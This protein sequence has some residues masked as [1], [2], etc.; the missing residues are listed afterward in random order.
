MTACGKLVT[1][2]NSPDRDN[3]QAE[4][5]VEL[6]TGYP[7]SVEL[8]SSGAHPGPCA[9]VEQPQTVT[10]R[11]RWLETN[12]RRTED[13]RHASSGLGETQGRP[14]TFAE[15]A[16][17]DPAI[18]HP[19]QE[20]PCPLC[21]GRVLAKD[22]PDHLRQVHASTA[23]TA[24]HRV[25]EPPAK[26]PLAASMA[27]HPSRADRPHDQ[28]LP[29]PNDRPVMHE[30]LTD[31]I[32]KRLAIGIERYGTGL[33]PMNGRDAFRDL[34]EELVD[35]SVYT[36]QIQHER[37]EMFEH[38]REIYEFLD[39]LEEVRIPIEIRKSIDALVNWLETP[40]IKT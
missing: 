14:L 31:L 24:I 18:I 17:A 29:E 7:C 40:V 28:A 22:L 36:L 25:P 23:A 39:S 37:A 6:R 1:G 15:H 21:S 30:V 11:Q 34:V 16:G 13:L 12:R 9:A 32:A 19:A 10:S 8:E 27:H 3:P 2:Y 5:W 26:D 20:V 35:A 33:Q 4:H 38:A